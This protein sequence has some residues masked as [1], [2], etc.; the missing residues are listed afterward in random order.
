MLFGA[1]TDLLSMRFASASTC[2]HVQCIALVCAHN[3]CSYALTLHSLETHHNLSVS[4]SL[5]LVARK[6]CNAIIATSWTSAAFVGGIQWGIGSVRYAKSIAVLS[7]IVY[8][9]AHT[10]SCATHTHTPV[11]K[12]PATIVPSVKWLCVCMLRR[13]CSMPLLVRTVRASVL[14]DAECCRCI[15]PD[16]FTASRNLSVYAY[17]VR[18]H[19]CGTIERY[20]CESTHSHHHLDL[21]LSLSLRPQ[22]GVYVNLNGWRKVKGHSE[23][24]CTCG[25]Y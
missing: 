17:L 8:D 11:A 14:L 2:Q 4:V 15:V 5:T 1:C 7:T 16:V 9:S 13:V 24:L 20:T 6:H 3:A 19:Q 21:S 23:C 22:C 12:Q 25:L 10:S 18:R